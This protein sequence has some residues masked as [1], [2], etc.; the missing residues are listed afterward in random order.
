MPS[1]GSN[2]LHAKRLTALGSRCF[3][4]IALIVR[5]PTKPRLH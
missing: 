5:G 4:T 1:T 3:V 2:L